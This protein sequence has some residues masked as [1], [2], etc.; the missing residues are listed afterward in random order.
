M[1]NKMADSLRRFMYG[2]A[3]VDKLS[4]ALIII[5]VIISLMGILIDSFVFTVL[6][7]ILLGL[8]L[9]RV[10]S[11]DIQKRHQEN[12]MFQGLWGQVLGK[13][14][15]KKK[16]MEMKKIYCLFQCPRCSQKLRMPKNK[17]V[18]VVTCSRCKCEFQQKT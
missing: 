5:G 12:M 10:L 16:E 18:V 1:I 15:G 11:K 3:G 2:R 14:N 7:Y 6:Y 17:G 9:Y 8:V 13:I 4:Y